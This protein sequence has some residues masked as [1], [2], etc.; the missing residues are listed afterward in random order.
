MRTWSIVYHHQDS[1]TSFCSSLLSVWKAHG[2]ALLKVPFEVVQTPSCGRVPR[3]SFLA[4]VLLR[5][6][7]LDFPRAV[8]RYALVLFIKVFTTKIRFL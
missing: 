4:P 7:M 3:D 2:K 5:S 8:A 6:G 1:C